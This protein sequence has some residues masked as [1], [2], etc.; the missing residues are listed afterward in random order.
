[1]AFTD[2]V[3]NTIVNLLYQTGYLGVFL[4]M[5]MESATLPVPSEVVL[6]LGG[7]L[8]WQGR[9][10][11]WSTV[12]V[13]TVGSL[14]GTMVDYGIGYYLGRPA[15]LRYGRIVRFSEKRL[16]TT[17][18]WFGSHGKNVVLLARFVPLLRTLIA[19]PA[20]LVKMDVKRFLAYSAVGILVWDIALVYLGFLAGQNSTAIASTLEAYFLPLGVAAVIIAGI[21]VYRELRTQ[22]G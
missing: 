1:M 10:E 2:L 19:F 6:P 16:E 13:A 8:V 3:F 4:L 22:K 14:V 11:F 9:L 21:L 12:A 15:V 7:Y 18:R 20:G 17:E 5:V